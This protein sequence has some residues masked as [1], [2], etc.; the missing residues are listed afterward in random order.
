MELHSFGV[1]VSLVMPGDTSTGF[2]GVRRYLTEKSSPFH[3]ECIRAVKKMENDERSGY[4]PVS[5]AKTIL[6]LCS[7]KNPPAR[8]VVGVDYKML[9][10]IRRLLPDK[11]I[12]YLLRKVYLKK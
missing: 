9:T 4:P 1:N 7:S 12:M 5:A 10:F 3:D 11:T 2:T 6:K 8:K